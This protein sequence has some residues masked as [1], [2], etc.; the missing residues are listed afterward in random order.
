MSTTDVLNSPVGSL[1]D[2]VHSTMGTSH[3]TLATGNSAGTVA[4]R[5]AKEVERQGDGYLRLGEEVLD[6]EY[7]GRVKIKC[8]SG[9]ILV[10]Q[11][12]VATQASAAA[13]ILGMLEASLS[14]SDNN[15]ERQRISGM[16]NALREVEYRVSQKLSLS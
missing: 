11:V 7:D 1:L 14:Q 10:D 2:Y 9:E 15:S 16:R 13:V 8:R 12:V 3:F 4:G 5:L 6:M